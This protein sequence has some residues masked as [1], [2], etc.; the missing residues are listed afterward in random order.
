VESYGAEVELPAGRQIVKHALMSVPVLRDLEGHLDF[1]ALIGR[2][3]GSLP[4]AVEGLGQ[5]RAGQYRQ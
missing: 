3:D 5:K 4:S 1:A 2:H